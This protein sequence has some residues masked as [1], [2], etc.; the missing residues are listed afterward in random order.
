MDNSLRNIQ[1]TKLNQE[2]INNLNRTITRHEIES[3]ILK[4]KNIPHKKVQDQM[5]SQVNSNKYTR[6]RL[7]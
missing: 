4:N 5:T 7:Y 6:K 1:P 2:E 3:V